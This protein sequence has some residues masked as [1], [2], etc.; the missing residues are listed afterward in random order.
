MHPP[1]SA[2]GRE[3]TPELP[4]DG[5]LMGNMLDMSASLVRYLAT[6]LGGGDQTRTTVRTT[7]S[8]WMVIHTRATSRES[9]KNTVEY[10]CALS[11]M[12]WYENRPVGDGRRLIVKREDCLGRFSE[13][14][15]T[16]IGQL[17]KD[18]AESTRTE[19]AKLNGADPLD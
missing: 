5:M 15:A 8:R 10:W 11:R 6:Q 7:I 1:T 16:Q 9:I 13:V 14:V 12:I 3:A 2:Q 18:G 19:P 4:T 17:R